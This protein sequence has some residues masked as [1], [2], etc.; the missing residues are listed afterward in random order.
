VL[1]VLAG[2]AVLAVLA[3]LACD[4]ASTVTGAA[5]GADDR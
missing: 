2:L 1:T 3:V 4:E 5:Y